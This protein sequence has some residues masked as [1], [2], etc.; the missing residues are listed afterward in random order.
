MSTA[1]PPSDLPE[2]LNLI[3]FP[4]EFPLKIMGKRVDDFAQTIAEVV[5]Q[6]A[7]DF[8]PATMEMRPS[9]SGKYL[10]LTCTINATSQE[11]LDSVYRALTSHSMVSYVL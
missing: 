5:Q 9:S 4:C 7:P 8:D 3:E 1:T 11:Q 2:R 6:F 10:G